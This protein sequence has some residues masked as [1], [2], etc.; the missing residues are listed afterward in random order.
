MSFG[1]N[2]QARIPV[3]VDGEESSQEENETKECLGQLDIAEISP[4]TDYSITI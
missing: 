2:E 1:L 4:M 3:I